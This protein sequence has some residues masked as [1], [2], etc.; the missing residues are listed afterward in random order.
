VLSTAKRTS[1]APG[2]PG[3]TTAPLV[4]LELLVLL[5]ELLV[6][7][8]DAPLPPP[9]CEPELDEVSVLLEDVPPP[10][11]PDAVLP[12]ELAEPP[13]PQAAIRATEAM[14]GTPSTSDRRS[15]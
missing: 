13:L 3:I 1:C 14:A 5:L 2:S 10:L 12:V 4:V 15:M 9:P 6:L 7:D 8:E 11:P